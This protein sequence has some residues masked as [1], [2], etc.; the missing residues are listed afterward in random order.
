[1][2]GQ[3]FGNDPR[4]RYI[5]DALR[6]FV[7]RRDGYRCRYC[8][9]FL[10]G[11][12]GGEVHIDHIYPF[13][14]GG[15]TVAENLAAACERC[16]LAKSDR[17]GVLPKP[18][19]YWHLRRLAG[20]VRWPFFGIALALA[21]VVT[22]LASLAFWGWMDGAIAGGSSILAGLALIVGWQEGRKK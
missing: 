22:A 19:D 18:Q 16:N 7:L 10:W 11:R 5:P 6:R 9:K 2:S 17:L 1:M 21:G 13:S 4:E 14:L 15:L 20:T 3:D 12:M 8:G